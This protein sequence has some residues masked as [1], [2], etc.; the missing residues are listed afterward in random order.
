MPTSSGALVRLPVVFIVPE[1]SPGSYTGALGGPPLIQDWFDEKTGSL[2]FKLRS[3]LPGVELVVYR[4]ASVVDAKRVL[5]IEKEAPG[6]LVVLLHTWSGG[7]TR[8]FIES[9]KPIVIIAESY[10]GG[11]ELL[12]ELGRALREGRPV[13]GVSLRDLSDDLVVR[14]ARLLLVIE[15]LKRSRVLFVMSDRE[16]FDSAKRL[17]GS[18]GVEA[19]FL[20]ARDFVEKYYMTIDR[21]DALIWSEKWVE[22]AHAVYENIYEEIVKSA[23][24]YLAMKRALQDHG[25]VSIAVDCI[26][27]YDAKILDAWPCLGYMQLWL[28]GYVPVCE[29]DPYSA[30]SLLIVWYLRDLPGFISDPVLDMSKDEVVYYHCYAPINPLGGRSRVRYTITPAHLYLKRASVYVELP[31]ER[32]I[33]ALQ[34]IPEERTLVIHRGRALRNE[35]GVHACATKLVARTNTRAIKNRWV[36]PWHRVVFFEDLV[37]DLRDLAALLGFRVYEEDRE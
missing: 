5:D 33:T 21:K 11:G 29:A 37:D 4:V 34:V 6:F 10:G 16:R 28:D 32:D 9:G 14:K 35:P 12:I 18:F 23:R 25:A 20:D 26:N 1:T 31:V 30:L 2:L 7:A 19:L 15:M 17:L 3:S 36:G 22:D 24:L 8:L 13:V 27:L